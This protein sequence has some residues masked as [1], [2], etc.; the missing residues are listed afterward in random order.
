[1]HTQGSGC[2]GHNMADDAAA[3]AAL[4]AVAVPG[5][6][7]KLQY[8]RA[9]EHAWEPYGSAMVIKTKAGVDAAGNVLDWDLELWSTPHGTRPGGDPGNLLSAKYLEKPFPQPV[10]ADGFPPNAY[11]AGRDAIANYD[12]PGHN[13]TE[14]YIT[15]MPLRVSSTRTLGAYAN[16]FAI[17]S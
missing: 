17:E 7:V 14:H 5:K 9:Q 8:T 12:F 10:P 15:E 4:L 2:Y 11:F 1:I 6:P 13:V 16:V 3:D